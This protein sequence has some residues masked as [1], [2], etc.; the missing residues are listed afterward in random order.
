MP[1]IIFRG[2]HIRYA[3]LRFKDEAGKFARLHMTADY[4]DPVRQ[5]FGWPELSDK[6]PSAK[7][8]GELTAHQ[9]ILT[10]AAKELRQHEIQIECSEVSDFQVVRVQDGEDKSHTELRFIARSNQADAAARVEQYLAVV[11]QAKAQL[12]VSHERQEGLDFGGD[13]DGEDASNEEEKEEA[14]PGPVL[15]SVVTNP[16]AMEERRKARQRRRG[17]KPLNAV[18][19]AAEESADPNVPHHVNGGAQ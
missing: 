16:D 12:R 8:A 9:L 6:M 4:S 15:A 7:L 19:W 14:G 2:S 10:P 13:D 18:D 17:E 3:D 5:R 1:T 11:G